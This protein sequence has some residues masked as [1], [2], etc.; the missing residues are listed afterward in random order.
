LGQF[1]IP[2][3]ELESRFR[4]DFSIHSLLL[5]INFSKSGL[6]CHENSRLDS[7]AHNSYSTHHAKFDLHGLGDPKGNIRKLRE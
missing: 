5:G 3:T 6:Q 4:F 2:S 1:L 7:H